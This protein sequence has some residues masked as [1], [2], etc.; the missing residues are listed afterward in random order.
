MSG[1][2]VISKTREKDKKLGKFKLRGCSKT[3]GNPKSQGKLETWEGRRHDQGEYKRV[4]V[5]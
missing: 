1:T 2:R 4:G 5:S 3:Q